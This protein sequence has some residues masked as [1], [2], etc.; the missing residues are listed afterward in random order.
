MNSQSIIALGFYVSKV[1]S[2]F[3][4]HEG[5]F[6]RKSRMKSCEFHYNPFAEGRKTEYRE[7]EKNTY[8]I[9]TL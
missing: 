6:M 2:A 9:D 4:K 3:C 7:R 8:I 5:A 1:I